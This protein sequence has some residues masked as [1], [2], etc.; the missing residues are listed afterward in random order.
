MSFNKPFILKSTNICRFSHS[1]FKHPVYRRSEPAL[2]DKHLRHKLKNYNDYFPWSRRIRSTFPTFVDDKILAVNKSDTPNFAC[3][4]YRSSY[5]MTLNT[6]LWAEP[7]KSH[8]NLAISPVYCWL[9]WQKLLKKSPHLQIIWYGTCF[10]P[11][12]NNWSTKSAGTELKKDGN[13]ST[14]NNTHRSAWLY[15]YVFTSLH[16]VRTWY[17]GL[18]INEYRRIIYST[19]KGLLRAVR[20]C[21]A[22]RKGDWPTFSRHTPRRFRW[23]QRQIS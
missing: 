15:S 22:R 13:A 4:I 6:S 9:G 10:V 23:T 1:F 3:N 19:E 5:F 16:A 2:G 14:G 20:Q 7:L 21:M 17:S 11:L 12:F 8:Q 18:I